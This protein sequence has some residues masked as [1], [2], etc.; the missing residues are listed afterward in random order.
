MLA[1]DGRKNRPVTLAEAL[2]AKD[3][4][5]L[6]LN[7]MEQAICGQC[8]LEPRLYHHVSPKGREVAVW[9]PQKHECRK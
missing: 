6:E 9:I 5:P 7:R 8:G 4:G 1:T 3:D 2:G